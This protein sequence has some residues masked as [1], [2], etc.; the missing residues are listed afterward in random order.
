MLL[1]F[2]AANVEAIKRIEG[3]IYTPNVKL[4]DHR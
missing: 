1:A 4:T 2:G 3:V